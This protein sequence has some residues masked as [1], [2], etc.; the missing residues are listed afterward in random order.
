MCLGHD[1]DYRRHVGGVF[2]FL[3]GLFIF[4]CN[5]LVLVF[6]ITVAKCHIGDAFFFFLIKS[7]RG[8]SLRVLIRVSIKASGVLGDFTAQVVQHLI[9]GTEA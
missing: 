1:G 6:K 7:K 8:P 9:F 5:R 2:V 3:N 4:L